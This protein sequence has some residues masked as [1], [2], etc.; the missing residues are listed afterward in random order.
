[1]FRLFRKPK[2][3]NSVLGGAVKIL[4]FPVHLFIEHLLGK[5]ALGLFV[6]IRRS[7]THSSIKTANDR[8]GI[9]MPLRSS[10]DRPRKENQ[11]SRNLN[12]LRR[13]ENLSDHDTLR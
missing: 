13:F 1:M 8:N 2:K 7:D 11:W 6:P 10:L 12:E 4:G 9:M 3:N 5:F